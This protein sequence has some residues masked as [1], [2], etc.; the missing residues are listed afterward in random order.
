MLSGNHKLVEL[1]K[2]YKRIEQTLKKRPDLVPPEGELS[3]IEKLILEY[4][5]K[6]KTFEEFVEENKKPLRR[7]I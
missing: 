4:I 5:K 2:L 1:W 3:P 6:G 7:W